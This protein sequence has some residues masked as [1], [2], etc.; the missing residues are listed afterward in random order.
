MSSLRLVAAFLLIVALAAPAAAQDYPVDQG[1]ILLDGAVSLISQGGELYE[2]AGGDRY[3]SLLLNPTVLY[4]VAPGVAVGGEL[5]VENASQGDAS[6]TTIGVGPTLAYFFGGPD[7]SVY[8]F[9]GGKILYGSTNTEGVDASGLGFGFGAGANFMLTESV[10][11]STQVDYTIENLSVDQLDE[12][13]SGNTLRLLIG[14][15]AFLF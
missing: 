13:F 2:N 1:A 12:S 6:R 8:P 4:F 9:V 5:Y 7:S 14:V 3:N 15:A 11:I 10:A